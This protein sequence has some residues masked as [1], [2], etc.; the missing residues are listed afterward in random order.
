MGV[1]LHRIRTYFV[2]EER[3]MTP[4]S[5]FK[6]IRGLVRI[7]GGSDNAVIGNSADKLKVQVEFPANNYLTAPLGSLRITSAQNVFESLFS[8]NKQPLIWD[9]VV[10][11]VGATSVHSLNTG[12]VDMTLPITLGAQIVR[13][14]FRRIRYN[15]SRSTQVLAAGIL[16]APKAN[17]RK[18]IGQFDPLDGMFFEHDGLTVNL[19]RRTSTS[20]TAV[21]NKTAQAAWNIDKLDGTGPSQMIIDWTKHHL[22]YIQYAFQGFGDIVY[23]VYANGRIVYIHREMIA[24][25]SAFP[26]MRT[27][28]LPCRV[29]ITNTGTAATPTAISYNSFTVKNEGEDSGVEGQVLSYSAM[30]LKTINITNVPIISVRLRPGFERAIADLIKMSI[31]VQTADEVIWSLVV[32]PVLTGATFATPSSYTEIDLA[33]TAYSGGT[34]VLTGIMNQFSVP[35]DLDLLKT[36]NSVFGSSINNVNTIVSLVARSRLTTADILSVL[37]WREFP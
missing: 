2:H 32:N 20:G 17:V 8:F 31:F 1:H 3:D 9:E 29:E 37:V 19:V 30:P 10:T 12:S 6:F 35:S 28:H 14:T 27:A 13:Q 15:P 22:F 33:A 11:G 18:R 26:S 23:G 7:R 21:D 24:N 36:V 16:G 5:V 4:D 34:E 25:V